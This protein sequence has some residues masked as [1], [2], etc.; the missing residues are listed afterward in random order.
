[1]FNFFT[2]LLV[3]A[4]PE[5]DS[6]QS[7]N[8]TCNL[9]TIN[10]TCSVDLQKSDRHALHEEAMRIARCFTNNSE[11]FVGHL[12]TNMTE[13][14]ATSHLENFKCL[15]RTIK[16]G[17]DEVGKVGNAD[18]VLDV[19]HNSNPYRTHEELGECG[20]VVCLVAK[21]H[22]ISLLRYNNTRCNDVSSCSVTE[23]LT[24]GEQLLHELKY[25]RDIMM[26]GNMTDCLRHCWVRTF[27][28][29]NNR[30]THFN[31]QTIMFP[32]FLTAFK[33]KDEDTYFGIPV[34]QVGGISGV[35]T[36]SSIYITGLVLN[37]ILVRIFIRHEEMRKDSKLIIINIAI[38]DMLNL[39]LHSPPIDIFLVNSI[40]S[41]LSVTYVF[42]MV[43]GLNIYSVMMFSCHVYLT[44]L[45][46]NNRRNPNCKALKRY[47]AHAHVLTASLLACVAPVP[48]ISVIEEYYTV[49]FY[50]LI[51]YCVAPLCCSTLFSVG[52]SLYLGL[53]VQSVHC[54]STGH[55][56]LRSSRSR[57]ANTLVALIVVSAV[58]YVPYCCLPFVPPYIGEQSD[59]HPFLIP[60]VF[61][62]FN[63]FINP[64]ALYV[65]NRD[66]RRYFN[67]YLCYCCCTG[68]D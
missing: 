44:V 13:D 65:A 62:W 34:Q 25:I 24:I 43:I 32:H 36:L 31:T 68:R 50:V 12:T 40:H 18:E 66:F 22:D 55:E 10:D 67:K 20:C 59:D 54:G 17:Q 37:C 51:T 2:Q 8:I 5:V 42:Y 11:Q 48:L 64:I 52:T 35:I 30:D 9:T 41:P 19:F 16:M 4:L 60:W 28:G 38:A 47:G 3:M 33:S 63:S 45:P 27:M 57:S 61:V 7:I 26:C 14:E 6:I 46:V 39:I 15:L 49:S 56:T 58:S 21:F 23:V 1:M 53:C 29:V